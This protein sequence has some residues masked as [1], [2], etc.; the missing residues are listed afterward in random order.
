MKPYIAQ[1]LRWVI[2]DPIFMKY[3]YL[4]IADIDMFYIREP[5]PLHIQHVEHMTLT[6]LPFDNLIR[7][8]SR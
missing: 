4:Y 7:K 1:T 5:I 8:D 6:G 3:D 2:W